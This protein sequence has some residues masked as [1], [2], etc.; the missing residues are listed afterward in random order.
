MTLSTNLPRRFSRSVAPLN[1]I[2][3]VPLPLFNRLFK[4]LMQMKRRRLLA[5]EDKEEEDSCTGDC[6]YVADY[7]KG[8]VKLREEEDVKKKEK[9]G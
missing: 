6:I 9:R 2:A 8:N 3:Q 5:K 4:Y 7:I 1:D